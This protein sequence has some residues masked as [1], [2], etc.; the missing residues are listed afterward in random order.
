MWYHRRMV[1][2]IV[3]ALVA[4]FGL[5]GLLTSVVLIILAVAGVSAMGA[6]ALAGVSIASFVCLIAGY[7]STARNMQKMLDQ[8]ASLFESLAAEHV[9]DEVERVWSTDVPKAIGGPLIR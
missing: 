9:K 7:I 3:S 1:R 2:Y 4:L 5:L 8:Q 6:G